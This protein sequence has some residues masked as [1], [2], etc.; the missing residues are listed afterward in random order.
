MV[1]TGRFAGI[2][3]GMHAICCKTPWCDFYKDEPEGGL[4]AYVPP[5]F[6]AS[7]EVQFE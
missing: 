3:K 7:G 1:L 5:G 6:H 4:D 2:V